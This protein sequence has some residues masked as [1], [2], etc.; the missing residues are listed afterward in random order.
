MIDITGLGVLL[1]SFLTP[2]ESLD[3]TPKKN[4][5][6]RREGLLIYGLIAP[7]LIVSSYFYLIGRARFFVR[8]DVV[9]RK[10]GDGSNGSVNIGNILT[11]GN[12][13]SIEDARYLRIYLESPQVLED[14]EKSFDF[15]KAYAKKGIDFFAGLS[16]NPSKERKFDFFRRQITVSLNDT[17]GVLRVR[18]LAYDPKTA[19]ML[20]LFLI[21]QAETFVNELNQNVYRNQ[22]DFAKKEV[23]LNKNRV[24]KASEELQKFQR[25]NK[26][27]NAFSEAEGSSNLIIGLENELAKLKVNLATVTRRFVDPSAPEII[28][29]RDQVEELENLILNERISLASPEGQD[30]FRKIAKAKELEANL[31]FATDLYRTAL[32]VS[33]KTR[34]DSLQQQ[35]FMEIISKPLTPEDQWNYWRHKGFLTATFGLLVI[36]ALTKFIL[37]MADSHMN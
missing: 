15:Q 3:E 14:L 34:V 20:N 12:Q 2:K 1:K 21:D 37:G 32:T 31:N 16:S 19:E 8:S 25:D 23:V 35:R 30:L 6:Y 27:V 11:G 28:Y 22:L 26:I 17:S 36:F 13:G 24:K 9:V 5:K 4:K 18:T 7:I 10:A 33:E 29:L